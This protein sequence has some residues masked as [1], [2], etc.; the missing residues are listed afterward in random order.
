MACSKREKPFTPLPPNTSIVRNTVLV[1]YQCGSTEYLLLEV[2]FSLWQPYTSGAR[3]TQ[4]T[5]T[6]DGS[7]AHRLLG[8]AG[9]V[10]SSA[11]CTHREKPG[12]PYK[13]KGVQCKARA[14]RIAAGRRYL[15]GAAQATATA[16]VTV[17]ELEAAVRGTG[18]AG[19][20]GSWAAAARAAV[21]VAVTRPRPG[22]HPASRPGANPACSHRSHR[23]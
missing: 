10:S 2:Q 17:K 1:H 9:H 4:I 6:C 19:W 12:G 5:T 11:L 13:T 14:A 23:Q 3:H 18:K 20:D 15:K 16:A 22:P 21:V 7:P 8:G